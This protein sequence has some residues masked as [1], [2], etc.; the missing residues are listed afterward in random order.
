VDLAYNI[1]LS[2]SPSSQ[3]R[4]LALEFLEHHD[5]AE[6]AHVLLNLNEFIY[7]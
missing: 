7:R 3:E 5:L 6:F 1:A 4:T 2:R